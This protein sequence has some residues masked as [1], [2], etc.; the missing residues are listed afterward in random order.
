MGLASSL[1]PGRRLRIPAR[2]EVDLYPPFAFSPSLAAL[3][4]P[5]L[6][7][8][9]SLFPASLCPSLFCS[10]PFVPRSIPQALQ[11]LPLSPPLFRIPTPRSPSSVPFGAV[12]IRTR[13]LGVSRR[14]GLSWPTAHS[15]VT[16]WRTAMSRVRPRHFLRLPSSPQLGIAIAD[17]PSR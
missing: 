9:F 10:L 13:F 15:R 14:L 1:S 6:T 11:K 17:G 7:L 3:S 16:G 2:V 4:L 5:L 8:F 12:S